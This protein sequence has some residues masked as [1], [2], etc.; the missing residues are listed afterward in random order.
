MQTDSQSDTFKTTKNGIIINIKLIPKSGEN[1]IIEIMGNGSLKVKV[2]EPPIDNKANISLIKLLA[3]QLKI[4]KNQINFV[5]GQKSKLKTICI[6]DCS[7]N[8]LTNKLNTII[9]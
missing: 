1:K 2:K 6:K 7:Y 8:E 3:K 9:C 5:C 4:H